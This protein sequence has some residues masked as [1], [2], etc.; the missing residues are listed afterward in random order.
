MSQKGKSPKKYPP[1]FKLN[2]VLEAFAKGNFSTTAAEHGVHITQINKWKKQ[3]MTQG[4]LA[5]ESDTAKKTD[6]ERKIDQLEKALG[7]MAFENTIL[8]KTEQL[9]NFAQ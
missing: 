1:E 5:F 6:E 2:L 4:H 8:K 7:R 3:L 9:L